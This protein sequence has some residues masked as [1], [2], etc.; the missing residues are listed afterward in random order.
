MRNTKSGLILGALALL[1]TSASAF[2]EDVRVEHHETPSSTLSIVAKDGIYGGIAGAA[3]GGGILLIRNNG[4]DGKVLGI[5]TGVGLLAGVG[6]GF[7]DAA[8]QHTTATASVMPEID[9]AA[10]PDAYTKVSDNSGLPPTALLF[11]HSGQF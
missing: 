1:G 8:T 4:F 10:R 5:S 3:V 9:R 6:L 2:A 7:L 11:Q